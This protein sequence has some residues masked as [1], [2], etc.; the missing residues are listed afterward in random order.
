MGVL[1]QS[2]E[3]A[4]A[5]LPAAILENLLKEKLKELD[6]APT[7]DL[8]GKLAHHILSGNNGSYTHRSRKL[9]GNVDIILSEA[10]GQRL[11]K[12]L[13]HFRKEYIPVMVPK[14]ARRIARRTLKDLKL[15]W[16]DEEA[17]RDGELTG[18]RERLE[19][20][21]NKPL[22]KL[23]MLLTMVREWC[24]D[25]F[26]RE[27]ARKQHKKKAIEGNPDSTACQSYPSYG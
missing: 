15:R 24:E 26:R 4:I 13:R 25:V 16:P 11:S 21:W 23:R 9:S 18:F 1:Q 7:R 6:I 5:Q 14:M 10:D 22:G 8:P 17:R 19:S 12:T 2:L 3:E 20:R 27:R